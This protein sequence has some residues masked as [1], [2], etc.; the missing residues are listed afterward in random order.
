MFQDAL[1]LNLTL[2]GLDRHSV[3]SLSVLGANL[4]VQFGIDLPSPHNLIKKGE[5][6]IEVFKENIPQFEYVL[7]QAGIPI[8]VSQAPQRQ[9]QKSPFVNFF[10]DY[11]AGL[12][13]SI[14]TL[15]TLDIEDLIRDLA[16][17]RANR[18]TVY[19]FGNGGSASTASHF[20]NDFSKDRFK[21]YSKLFKVICLNDCVPSMTALANDQGYEDVFS[22]QLNN[23]LEPDDL[24]I[25]ISSSGNS[26]NIIKALD[27]ANRRSA[28]TWAWV[29]FDGGEA[30]KIAQRHIYIPSKKGQYG[31]MEDVSLAI[32][33]M[34]S[35]YFQEQDRASLKMR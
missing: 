23:L 3:D 16:E 26:P 24:V 13:R 12:Q 29:G 33:H 35:V 18:G 4:K 25:A 17:T 34:L 27:L 19:I 7:A 28:K 21:E 30:Q 32:T 15:D 14:D 1:P 8:V 5:F 31:F 6:T 22:A 9:Q 20:A 10:E 11:K 2:K